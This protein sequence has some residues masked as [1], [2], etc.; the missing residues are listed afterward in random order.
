MRND[1][2]T[3][4]QKINSQPV[5]SNSYTLSCLLY[6]GIYEFMVRPLKL[7]T[8]A[9]GS[10]YNLGMGARDTAICT[11]QLK[12]LAQFTTALISNTLQA[13]ITNVFAGALY[14][15]DFNNGFLTAG[16]TASVAYTNNGIYNVQ[17]KAI[18]PC[19]QDSSNQFVQIIE[20][21]IDPLSGNTTRFKQNPTNSVFEI[22][23]LPAGATEIKVYN[24]AGQ[25]IHAYKGPF[26][27]T[28]CASLDM[29]G[30]YSIQICSRTK[31]TWLPLLIHI[32]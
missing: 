28:F 1:S 4:F 6:K 29:S 11:K 12:A 16:P 2:Q 14:S 17:L 15:W 31:T 23:N 3:V 22:L 13:G 8:T 24:A 5:I 10:Y 18:H 20:A 25:V 19:L 26:T 32:N 30:I 27:N 7:E 21:Q 9:S